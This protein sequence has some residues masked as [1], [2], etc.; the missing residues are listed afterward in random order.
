MA[1]GVDDIISTGLKI[2]DKFIPDPAAKLKAQQELQSMAHNELMLIAGIEGD[3]IR[4]QLDVN[5][6][7]AASRSIFVS[8][9]RVL[10]QDDPRSDIRH[11]QP[12]DGSHGNAW[13]WWNENL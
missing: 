2:I 13:P 4:G 11:E 10:R 8:G 1:F 7:E 12:S 5:R 6:E 3:A 9:W